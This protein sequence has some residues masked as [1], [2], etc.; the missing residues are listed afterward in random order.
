MILRFHSMASPNHKKNHL[1]QETAMFS[2][3]V[4]IA[5]IG[6]IIMSICGITISEM[7][8]DFS[9]IKL[10]RTEARRDRDDCH[11]AVHSDK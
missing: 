10:K 7:P 8:E 2:A 1:I 11:G 5:V 3:M 6:F 4:S 9:R